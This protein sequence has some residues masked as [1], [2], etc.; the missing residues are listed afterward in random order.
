MYVGWNVDK[1]ESALQLLDQ[2]VDG[3]NS[4]YLYVGTW[5]AM[6]AYHTEDC[7]L[8]SINYVH[9]GQPK[10]WY[11]I[12]IS[13]RN[14][15][16]SLAKS[17][18]PVDHQQCKE[19]LRHKTKLFS[20]ARL[21]ERGI[22]FSTVLQTAG[23]F[24]ITFPGSY[25]AGFNHGFNIAE[26]VNFATPEWFPV[27][28][29]AK[30]CLCRT[31]SVRV[32]VRYLETMYLRY[33]LSLRNAYNTDAAVASDRVIDLG[34]S[35][36][37]GCG[38]SSS[39]KRNQFN[40]I[41]RSPSAS[42][43]ANGNVSS[44]ILS[45]STSVQKKGSSSVTVRKRLD[46]LK[47]EHDITA[48]Q[49]CRIRCLCGMDKP[50]FLASPFS[51]SP[52]SSHNNT[53]EDKNEDEDIVDKE[54]DE[55]DDS[56]DM[57]PSISQMQNCRLQ[58]V[59]SVYPDLFCCEH[60][61]IFSHIKCHSDRAAKNS[62]SNEATES[63]KARKSKS[64]IE[65]S[66]IDSSPPPVMVE[67]SALALFT[68]VLLGKN[69]FVHQ[70]TIDIPQPKAPVVIPSICH[71]CEAVDGLKS[72]KLKKQKMDTNGS[73]AMSDLNSNDKTNQMFSGFSA[74]DRKH[75]LWI[76]DA[77]THKYLADENM[78]PVT[79][80]SSITPPTS[81]L[82]AIVT[83]VV[84]STIVVSTNNNDSTDN[85]IP[86]DTEV[87]ITGKLTEQGRPVTAEIAATPPAPSLQVYRK[88]KLTGEKVAIETF[89][90]KEAAEAVKSSLVNEF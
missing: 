44:T 82:L 86:N 21:K 30:H 23:E 25:H 3:V 69:Y 62:N 90:V 5:R 53:I 9:T 73:S 75:L 81:V 42:T 56:N 34:E 43:S 18:F 36:H 24:V 13:E 2:N 70:P 17:Y 68:E 28:R 79:R 60:C 52:S 40:L 11:A 88:N 46:G 61:G 16:E 31:D 87:L 27:G 51:A 37:D 76:R 22:K 54:A 65:T 74:T 7:D 80:L 49:S 15:F 89:P 8:F 85:T 67:R 45:P 26:A 83:P 41:N 1:L 57:K 84:V 72:R 4:S 12:P 10:S 33:L 47:I 39:A 66:E 78:V 38:S 35:Q 71:I 59:L 20:P 55:V 48:I 63:P 29:K 58:E 77:Y 64:K 6:F 32:D 50:I 19:F 14:R